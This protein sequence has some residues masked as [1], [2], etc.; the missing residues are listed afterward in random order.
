MQIIDIVE[1][2]TILIYNLKTFKIVKFY[3]QDVGGSEICVRS[4]I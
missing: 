4:Y 3:K 1:Q 2:V